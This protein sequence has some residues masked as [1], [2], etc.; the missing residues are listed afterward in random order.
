MLPAENADG[1]ALA[2]VD[3]FGALSNSRALIFILALMK[4]AAI[5]HLGA[6]QALDVSVLA[7]SSLHL[8]N[9]DTGQ[10]RRQ[11]IQTGK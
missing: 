4:S 10:R 9:L 8:S 2:I 3:K 5:G 7:L 6:L 11:G 1:R